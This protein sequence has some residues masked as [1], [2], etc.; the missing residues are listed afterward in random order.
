MYLSNI[1]GRRIEASGVQKR[2]KL[3]GRRSQSRLLA[4]KKIRRVTYL[5]LGNTLQLAEVVANT[6]TSIPRVVVHGVSNRARALKHL[7]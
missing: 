2:C 7:C 4:Y 3:N 6:I 1:L 5:H